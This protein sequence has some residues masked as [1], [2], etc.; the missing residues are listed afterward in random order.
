MGRTRFATE[1]I[2][3]IL[4]KN[5]VINKKQL[6][7][8]LRVQKDSSNKRI[9]EIL[10]SLCFAKEEDIILVL[11]IQYHFP[12]ISIDNYTVNSEAIKT[13]PENI[14]RQYLVIP[15]DRIGNCFTVAMADPLDDQAVTAIEQLT[16]CHVE[17]FIAPST[18]IERN[19]AKY[20]NHDKQKTEFPDHLK[21]S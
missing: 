4:V 16:H 1:R 10:T 7:L 9:G 20:Y 14:A 5:G 6:S 19:I 17:A 15:L 12:Y 13:I 2:G 3:E 8:A 18:D 11:I 21:Y